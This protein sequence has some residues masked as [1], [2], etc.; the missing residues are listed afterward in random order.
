VDFAK[1]DDEKMTKVTV[2]SDVIALA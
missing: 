2:T 1:L